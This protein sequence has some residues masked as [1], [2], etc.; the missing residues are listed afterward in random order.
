MNDPKTSRQPVWQRWLFEGTQPTPWRFAAVGIAAIA[1]PPA[2]VVATFGPDAVNSLGMAAF[3]AAMPAYF[4]ALYAG[5]AVSALVTVVTGMAGLLSLGNPS[6]ALLV[7]PTLAIMAAICGSYGLARPALQ[8]LLAWTIFTSPFLQ[9]NN[10][11]L[12]FGVYL[13]AMVW[14]LG[15]AKLFG[16][17]G[18]MGAEK[19]QSSGY[20]TVFGMLLAIGMLI[21][22]GV[23][24]RYFGAHGYWFPFT[25]VIVSLPPHAQLLDRSLKR[26]V[27]TLFGAIVV[28]GL[29]KLIEPT[30]VHVAVAVM[31]Q[32]LAV[33]LMPVSYVGATTLLTIGILETAA[34][35][36]A[37]AIDV[38]AFERLGT[39][40]AAALLTAALVAMG[41]LIFSLVAPEALRSRRK[42]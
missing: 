37:V 34:L 31:S 36:T 1:I 22:I 33:R 40:A 7:G 38:V 25:F 17:T 32:L 30:A 11:T 29:G 12:T 5:I 27:G 39:V 2:V 6:M 9:P 8:A 42:S 16:H 41:A 10:P 14:S 26:V 18:A 15:I 20:A 4:A 24:N 35:S 21:S 23:G 13:A 19:P 3:L 28:V